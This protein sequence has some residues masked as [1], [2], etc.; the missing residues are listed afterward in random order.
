MF[1]ADA[2]QPPRRPEQSESSE[3]ESETEGNEQGEDREG[4]DSA[5]GMDQSSSSS[6]FTISSDEE[7]EEKN[8]DEP[9]EQ[10]PVLRRRLKQAAGTEEIDDTVTAESDKNVDR[11]IAKKR[12]KKD[13][14]SDLSAND[15]VTVEMEPETAEVSVQNNENEDP[16]EQKY[17]VD[18][19]E[20]L[21]M[22]PQSDGFDVMTLL[23]FPAEG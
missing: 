17:P 15:E 23:S 10:E 18:D 6:S 13:K 19:K 21:S 1:T 7:E 3:E 14:N 2:K 9:K 22:I 12:V 16:Y 5:L 20:A 8:I 4:N 11:D